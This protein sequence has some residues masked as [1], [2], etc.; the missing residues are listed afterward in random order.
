MCGNNIWAFVRSSYRSDSAATFPSEKPN[1]T[2]FYFNIKA[3]AEPIRYLF[4]YGGQA[5][6]DVR[7]TRDEWPALKPSEYT[8]PRR[9]TH[10]Y[11]PARPS[12]TISERNVLS[13][14]FFWQ[15]SNIGQCAG[16]VRERAC[17]SACACARTQT[18]RIN[19]SCTVFLAAVA[20]AGAMRL[21]PICARAR[22]QHGDRSLA[23]RWPPASHTH[24]Q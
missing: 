6:E 12:S 18:R 17:T 4:A 19:R 5:F 3:L 20:G 16:T 1:F 23:T 2:L 14:V 11:T 21:S 13:L 15:R 8:G 9:H 22:V 24:I 7:V 10:T